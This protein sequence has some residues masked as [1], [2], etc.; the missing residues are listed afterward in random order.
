MAKKPK[1][2]QPYSGNLM[3]F[4]FLN[5]CLLSYIMKLLVFI[6]Y[7]GW[8]N[9][10][11]T[12]KITFKLGR[13]ILKALKCWD[14]KTLENIKTI[15]AC[16]CSC[17]YVKSIVNGGDLCLLNNVFPGFHINGV[18]SDVCSFNRILF[19]IWMLLTRFDRDSFRFRFVCPMFL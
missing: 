4:L 9:N 18:C 1:S 6:T 8:T 17:S 15:S 11:I 14:L 16:S 3:S 2:L 19:R 10:V 5:K 7:E 13:L 12:L